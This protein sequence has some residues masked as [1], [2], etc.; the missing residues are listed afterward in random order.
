MFDTNL[1]AVYPDLSQALRTGLR[2]LHFVGLVLG[3]GSA[4]LLDVFLFR[5]RRQPVT[6]GLA[7]LA[8]TAGSLVSAGLA[9]LWATGL[10]FLFYYAAFDPPR[11]ENPKVWAKVAIVL[12]LSINGIFIHAVALPQLR[13]SVGRVFLSSLSPVRQHLFLSIGMVSAVSW[14]GAML[15]GAVPQLNFVV[16][17]QMILALYGLVLFC[18]VC[19]ASMLVTPPHDKDLPISGQTNAPL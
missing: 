12:V 14:Y 8:E 19:V 17:A 10:G 15:L 7:E 2:V 18:G 13:A 1:A 5:S 4:T 11:L 3:L 16:P 6:A 9:V